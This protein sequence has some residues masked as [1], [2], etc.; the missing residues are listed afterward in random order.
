LDG[1]AALETATPLDCAKGI[2]A[3]PVLEAAAASVLD[4]A[5]EAERRQDLVHTLAAEAEGQRDLAHT[6]AAEV[7]ARRGLA[8]IL[9]AEAD[10]SRALA[11]TL[12]AGVV[13]GAASAAEVARWDL[14]HMLA[15]V[16]AVV[17][18]LALVAAVVHT[19]ALVAAVVETGPENV[20]ASAVVTVAE[21]MLAAA[22]E[23]G[24]EDT[25][26]DVD[27]AGTAA[28]MVMAVGQQKPAHTLHDVA[29]V[30]LVTDCIATAA[31][32]RAESRL[33]PGYTL[34][35]AVQEPE[36]A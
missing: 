28:A 29:A 21:R 22:G 20:E 11:H 8:H 35:A 23:P 33:G 16:A 13:Q 15:L 7:D 34:A 4:V 5:V 25:G 27:V 36:S 10:G 9:A 2:A 24:S 18:T 32:V 17:H 1:C 26:V 14:V 6:L 31:A 30:V 3:E 12:A 19:L